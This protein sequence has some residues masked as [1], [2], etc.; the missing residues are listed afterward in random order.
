[1]LFEEEQHLGDCIVNERVCK[2]II[3][4]LS[5]IERHNYERI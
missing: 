5:Y 1:M 2:Y 4:I 3:A